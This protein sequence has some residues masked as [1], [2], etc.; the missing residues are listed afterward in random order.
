MVQTRPGELAAI[1]GTICSFAFVVGFIF[2][3][4][5]LSLESRGYDEAAIGLNATASGVGV[6]A[7]GLVLARLIRI[8]GTFGVLAG[9]TGLCVVLMILFPLITDYWAWL[10]FRFLLGASITGL[11][12][13]GEAW[14]VTTAD[15]ASRGRT[16]S[17][18][19]M[20]M[21][22]SFAVGALLV[23]WTGFEGT[24]P[25]VIAAVI[26]AVTFLPLIPFRDRNPLH[27]EIADEEKRKSL[28]LSVLRS[29]AF[30][31]LVVFLF[32]LL[33]GVILGLMPIYALAQGIGEADAA[34]P[35]AAMALGVVLMQ[36]P[37]GYILDRSDKMQVLAVVLFSVVILSFMMPMVSLAHWTGTVFLIVYGGLSFGPYTIAL[38]IMGDRFRGQ[39]LAAASALF[40]IM[41]GS[42]GTIGPT[43]VGWGME[44]FGAAALP[45][46]LAF[47][48]LFAAAAAVFE[49]RHRA[50]A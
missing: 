45:Y 5:A 40:G 14:I 4:I 12:A 15:D 9:G 33:D 25:F 2:P 19:V 37:L 17:I 7:G 43:A 27:E 46:S 36:W 32:G 34:L 29:A 10:F 30:L 20:A 18:Y 28:M 35:V 23:K 24:M 26:V 21:S 48:F 16:V 50:R 31:M 44:N 11:F 3:V 13:A 39:T 8:W 22:V 47:C 49:L 1:I 38:S 42:G 41:W 6:A